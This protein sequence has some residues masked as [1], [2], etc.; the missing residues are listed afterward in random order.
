[1]SKWYEPKY[2]DMFLDDKDKS[3][4]AYLYSDNMGA[5]YATFSRELI[6]RVIKENKKI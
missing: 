2:E 3:I 4:S 5:I 1:M 6:E